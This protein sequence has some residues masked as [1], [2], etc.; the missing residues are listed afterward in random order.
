M[1]FNILLNNTKRAK[2]FGDQ[3]SRIKNGIAIYMWDPDDAQWYD[4]DLE[5]KSK[6]KAPYASNYFPLWARSHQL[7]TQELSEV[8]RK[9]NVDAV[10]FSNR[11]VKRNL[12][13]VQQW[14]MPNTWAPLQDILIQ[15]LINTRLASGLEMAW[16]IASSWIDN[17]MKT[18]M[19]TGS[20]FEKY[21][22]FIPGSPGANGE[23]T[24]Q[25]GFGWTNGVAL[26]YLFLYGH[27]FHS[28]K[29][30]D[31]WRIATRLTESKQRNG[32]KQSKERRFLLNVRPID[33]FV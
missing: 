27:R 2:Y 32:G 16:K 30:A 33:Y 15:G 22:A 10:S 18:L 20:M 25:D 24:V 6:H 5:S 26:R 12:V 13:N 28:R 31:K 14:D 19:S 7:T 9:M 21:N 4:Y 23:Y 29:S 17:N 1:R 3:R 11:T 8:L